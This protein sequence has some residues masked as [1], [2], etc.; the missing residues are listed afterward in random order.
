M[1]IESEGIDNWYDGQLIN[2][3][4]SMV[5][6]NMSDMWLVKRNNYILFSW[7]VAL[8]ST[9]GTNVINLPEIINAKKCITRKEF[10]SSRDSVTS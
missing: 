9:N 6:V 3:P 10:Y 2:S 7:D 1:V 8:I 4:R 5:V